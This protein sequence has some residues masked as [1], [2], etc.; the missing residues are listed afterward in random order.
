MKMNLSEKIFKQQSLLLKT[1]LI[2]VV[3]TSFSS[4]ALDYYYTYQPDKSQKGKIEMLP[5]V[6]TYQTFVKLND[7]IIINRK[8]VKSVT[9]ENLPDG[10]YR[11]SYLSYDPG[12]K[13][14][15]EKT[16]Y[17]KIE[18]GNTVTDLVNVP[19]YS[20]GYWIYAGIL[21]SSIYLLYLPL[22]TND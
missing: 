12:Y 2:I 5:I 11:L 7:S 18:N 19:P 15:M 14:K 4:C 9:I 21:T 20:T 6:P 22:M 1:I 13:E 3:I 16:L 8:S 10:E 17:V